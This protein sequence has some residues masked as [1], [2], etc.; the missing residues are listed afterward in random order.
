M[1]II[2]THRS[3]TGLALASLTLFTACTTP[4]THNTAIPD[5]ESTGARIY[6]A[7][8]SNCHALP[9]PQRL[10][11]NAWLELLPIMEQRMQERG[12]LKMGKDERDKLL[13]YLKAHSR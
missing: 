7:R 13:A 1:K 12:M 8:C 6:S 2:H 10:G 3:I 9:H 11:Y 5:A 4:G